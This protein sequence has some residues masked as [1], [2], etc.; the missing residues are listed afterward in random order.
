MSTTPPT[1]PP[2]AAAATPTKPARQNKPDDVP[3]LSP[4]LVVRDVAAAIDFYQQAF[5]FA[6]Q[7]KQ[8]GSDGKPFH[9][10]L[11]WHDARI[12]LGPENADLKAPVTRGGATGHHYVYVDNVDVLFERA[13]DGG[14]M[15]LRSPKNEYWGDRCC[16]VA[17]PDGHTWM[18]AAH[19]PNFDA[20]KAAHDE[21]AQQTKDKNQ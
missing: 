9:A 2:P 4:Y 12:Q 17:D 6:L 19:V 20:W 3:W 21:L 7:S 13:L 8:V 16:L 5:C 1:S 15:P 11:A 18:F 10:V 14:A